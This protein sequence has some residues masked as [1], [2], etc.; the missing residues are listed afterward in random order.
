M[1]RADPPVRRTVTGTSVVALRGG[2]N[3]YTHPER[4]DLEA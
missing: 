3:V 2:L 1:L 4:M